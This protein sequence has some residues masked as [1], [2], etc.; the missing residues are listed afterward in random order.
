PVEEACRDG[1]GDV[2]QDLLAGGAAPTPSAWL[3]AGARGD[4]LLVLLLERADQGEPFSVDEWL[5]ALARAAA[6][7]APAARPGLT[8]AMQAVLNAVHRTGAAK[9][10]QAAGRSLD[11]SIARVLDEPV[12][13]ADVPGL[14]AVFSEAVDARLP[15]ARDSAAEAL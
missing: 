7:G 13:D 14:V 11:A 10:L 12:D 15:F 2:V 6:P 3:A 5:Q 8:R 4:P 1:R 9:R